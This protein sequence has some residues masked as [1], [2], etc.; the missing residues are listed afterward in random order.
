MELAQPHSPGVQPRKPKGRHR[1]LLLLVAFP[2]FFLKLLLPLRSLF[3]VRFSRG[4]E[5]SGVAFKEKTVLLLRAG[6]DK[7]AG[8]KTA[9]R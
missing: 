6:K 2:P 3:T 1:E 7:R 9:R 4:Q 5:P 8:Y